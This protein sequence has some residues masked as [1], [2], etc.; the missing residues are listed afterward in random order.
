MSF[1]PWLNYI[2][3]AEKSSFITGKIRKVH[4]KC[5]DGAEMLEEYNMDTGVLMRRGWKKKNDVLCLQPAGDDMNKILF[6]WDIELGEVISTKQS[7]DFVVKESSAAVRYTCIITLHIEDTYFCMYL[8]LQPILT[9][10]LTRNN[11]EW[12]IRNL[13]Y[14][15]ETYNVTA[16]QTKKMIVVRTTNKKYFKEIPVPELS[17]CGLLPSQEHISI[18]HQLNTLIITV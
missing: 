10:R 5:N 1:G 7:E 14:S 16:D 2:K 18:A 11:I 15:L 17:R 3:N 4:Y 8:P 9:K 12:R 13:P 6:N